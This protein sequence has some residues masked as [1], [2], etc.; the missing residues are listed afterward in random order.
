MFVVHIVF[1]HFGSICPLRIFVTYL[2]YGKILL[3]NSTFL[4]LQNEMNPSTAGTPASSQGLVLPI[5]NASN[6]N[7]F[8]SFMMR[9]GLNTALAGR[10]RPMRDI[11]QVTCFKVVLVL[12]SCNWRCMLSMICCSVD[13]KGTM[14]IDVSRLWGCF[15]CHFLQSQLHEHWKIKSSDLLNIVCAAQRQWLAVPVN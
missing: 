14:Q 1:I 4:G 12:L 2:I 10:I 3:S 15:Q 13:A 7:T 6:P 9:P 11:S 8:S 5:P